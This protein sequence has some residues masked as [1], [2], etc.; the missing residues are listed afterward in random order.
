MTEEP[1]AFGASVDEHRATTIDA[2]AKR[3]SPNE[4][5]F[6]LGVFVDGGLRGMVGFARET[7][8]KRRHRAVVW[9]VYV[10]PDYRG[11][12]LARRLLEELVRRARAL[13]GLERILLAANAADPA[14]TS[15]YKSLG[16]RT[17][18]YERAALKIGE[19]YVDDEHMALD[20]KEDLGTPVP[21]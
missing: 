10:A 4:H 19:R 20:L 6:V 18:G 8:L 7:S 14:A 3:I 9:G 1:A 11:R 17:F 13:Y 21:R 15:L 2:A 16:F 12:G 5:N